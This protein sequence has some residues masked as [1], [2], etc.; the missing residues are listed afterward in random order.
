MDD[1]TLSRRIAATPEQVWAVLTDLD[2]AASTLQGVT[3]V[4]RLT[5][6]P[7]SVGT[8]WR[9]TRTMFGK[10]STQ[11]MWVA[12][13]DPWRRSLIQAEAGGTAYETEFRLEQLGADPAA[14]NL[15]VRFGASTTDPSGIQKAVM[16]VFGGWAIKATT[17]A[18][19]QDLA[20]I[21]AAAEGTTDIDAAAEGTTDIVTADDATD[22]GTR[23]SSPA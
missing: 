4:E 18:L 23:D 3:R 22:N 8:R 13:N 16:K 11:E 17:K 15:T 5:D 10:E 9:E 2:N 14:T 21:A 7:Y 6:G 1:L 20:D 19:K 12:E